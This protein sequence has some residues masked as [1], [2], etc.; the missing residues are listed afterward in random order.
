MV[1]ARLGVHNSFENT[2]AYLQSWINVLK[3]D[4]RAIF[5]ASGAAQAAADWMFETGV[6]VPD[7][8]FDLI[9]AE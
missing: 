8:N 5:R 1:C 7:Q 3:T 6:A 9:A 4:S 2:A